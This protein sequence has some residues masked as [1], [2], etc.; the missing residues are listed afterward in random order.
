MINRFR[1]HDT[2]AAPV[3]SADLLEAVVSP[4]VRRGAPQMALDEDDW[5]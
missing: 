5:R 2:D 3:G 1:L 4:T